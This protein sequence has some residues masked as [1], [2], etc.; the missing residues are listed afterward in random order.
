MKSKA[1]KLLAAF[2]SVVIMITLFSGCQKSDT[3]DN[4]FA[5]KTS[6]NETETEDTSEAKQDEMTYM[7]SDGF[8][9]RYN[10]ETFESH[11]IDEHSA[12]FVYLPEPSGND[13]V[14][15]SY[16]SG[17]QPEELLAEITSTWGDQDKI[18]QSEGFFPGTD[19]K[20]GYWRTM[21][22]SE[23]DSGLNECVI[24]G[25]Y[26]G[27]VLVFEITSEAEKDD[28]PSSVVSDMLSSVI[29]SITYDNFEDQTMYDN[30]VG[31]YVCIDNGYS[32]TLQ[33]DHNADLNLDKELYALW[34]TTEIFG[35]DF[36]YD[37]SLEGDALHLEY[38]T[39]Q[40]VFN[41]SDQ[42]EGLG[43]IPLSK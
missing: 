18:S 15:I 36:S 19:D 38:D 35:A 3:K 11:E 16:V 20:W 10:P 7:S 8:Q 13:K 28:N 40:L 23:S 41:R 39:G 21:S 14:I 17:K 30:F 29:D 33:K 5:D 26:N 6:E 25:E 27:G 34:G 9:V 31:T 32:V 43:D 37:Y 4:G 24:A 22:A 42:N 2:C 1:K 12:D